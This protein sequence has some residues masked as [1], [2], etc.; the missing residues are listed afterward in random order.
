M[1]ALQPLLIICIVLILTTAARADRAFLWDS[2]NGLQ[3]LGSL[4]GNSYA[5]GINDSGQVVG[6]SYLSDNVTYHAFIWTPAT[7]MVDLGTPGGTWSA[8]YGIN[9]AGHVVGNGL[10]A[11][12]NQIAFFWSPSGGFVNVGG[13]L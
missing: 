2:T 13:T 11:A 5:E 8:A 1:K 12:G 3:D 9:A 10:D 6:L 7:G 4:G